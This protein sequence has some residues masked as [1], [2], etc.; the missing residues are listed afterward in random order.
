MSIG[1][2]VCF[3]FES[4][5][6]FA[7]QV[8]GGRLPEHVLSFCAGAA[9]IAAVLP[10]ARFLSEHW[11]NCAAAPSAA[12]AN[13]DDTSSKLRCWGCRLQTLLPS[14]IGIAGV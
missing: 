8:N 4:P 5:S 13:G 9:V 6:R 10:L 11:L 12:A 7:K 1:T 2:V 14:G 3:C